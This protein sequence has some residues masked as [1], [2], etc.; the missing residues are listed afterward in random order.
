MFPIGV[1]SVKQ[2][3][4]SGIC[5]RVRTHPG[6][7]PHADSDASPCCAAAHDSGSVCLARL[8]SEALTSPFFSCVLKLLKSLTQLNLR[9][10]GIARRMRLIQLVA[11]R[12]YRHFY[13]Y[14]HTD[15]WVLITMECYSMDLCGV[16]ERII[17]NQTTLSVS[18]Y[19]VVHCQRDL[20]MKIPQFLGF[21]SGLPLLC[22]KNLIYILWPS[23][24]DHQLNHRA[25]PRFSQQIWMWFILFFPPMQLLALYALFQIF[26]C[27]PGVF[28]WQVCTFVRNPLSSPFWWAVVLW[29]LCH[30]YILLFLAS[31]FRCIFQQFSIILNWIH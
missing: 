1:L 15:C 12:K 31:F 28:I 14:T 10:P 27:S 18:M 16:L 30:F 24:I 29:R 7:W 2:N 6:M 8:M 17:S 13:P 9:N 11:D 23:E 4:E 25:K 26:K 20:H 5:A 21:L 3:K 22:V 19:Y